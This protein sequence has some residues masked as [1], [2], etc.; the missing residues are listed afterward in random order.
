MLGALD[1][2]AKLLQLN[3]RIDYLKKEKEALYID[4]LK[5]QIDQVNFK[6]K[7]KEDQIMGIEDQLMMIRRSHSEMNQQEEEFKK[8]E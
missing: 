4:E 6:I 3:G 8:R 7:E 5:S 1:R 2:D